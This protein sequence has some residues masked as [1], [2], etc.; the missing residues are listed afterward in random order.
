MAC[1]S[2][3]PCLHYIYPVG[4]FSQFGSR[5]IFEL[6]VHYSVQICILWMFSSSDDDAHDTRLAYRYRDIQVFFSWPNKAKY[7]LRI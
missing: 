6:K 7:V 2:I 1:P 5:S 4:V 3:R